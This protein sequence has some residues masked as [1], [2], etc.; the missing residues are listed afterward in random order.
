M[1]YSILLFFFLIYKSVLSQELPGTVARWKMDGNCELIDAIANPANG[2]LLDVASTANK[3]Q[4]LGSAFLFNSNTSYIALGVVEKL[5]L[6]GD[7]SISFWI[8]PVL[9]GADRTGSIFCYGAG[10]NIQYLEQGSAAK[11]N[12]MYGNTSYLQVNL[13]HGSWQLVAIT[14][15]KSFSAATSKVVAYVN[16]TQVGESERDK[17]DFDFNNAIAIIGPANQTTLT[18]GFRGSLDDLRFYNRVLTNEE[19]NKPKSLPTL[20]SF[21]GKSVYGLVE[22]AWQRPVEGNVSHFFIQRSLDGIEFENVTKIVA[23]KFKYSIYDVT[24]VSSGSIWYRLYAV[25]ASGNMEVLETIR[26]NADAPDELALV[27]FP[28]PAS[29]QLKLAAPLINGNVTIVNGSGMMIRQQRLQTG[30]NID[31]SN[32]RPGLYYI[33]LFDG[34]KKRVAK[35]IKQ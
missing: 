6:T 25:N 4:V 33:I 27:V 18:N 29:K 10:I 34:S 28:N 5:K 11:L 13:A 21:K 8:N 7:Q 12:I 35:F 15:Q 19:I 24:G 30:N 14:F 20:T 32:L 9:S 16:G 1:R 2:A 22:L 31:V 3:D 23:G 17:R 26:V